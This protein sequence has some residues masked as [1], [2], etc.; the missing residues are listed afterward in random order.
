MNGR[1]FRVFLTPFALAAVVAAARYSAYQIPTV[2]AIAMWIFV[3]LASAVVML[4][5]IVDD[6]DIS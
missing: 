6:R 5:V 3:L 2:D 1:A 4:L